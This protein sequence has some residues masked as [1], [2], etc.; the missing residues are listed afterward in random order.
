MISEAP[1]SMKVVLKLGEGTQTI[2]NISLEATNEN[3]YAIGTAVGKL[4]AQRVD[5]IIKVQ[6]TTLINE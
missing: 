3:L 6:E 5:A 2:S 4:C 1:K